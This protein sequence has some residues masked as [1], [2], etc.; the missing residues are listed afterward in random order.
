MLDKEVKAV[1]E[2]EGEAVAL[3]EELR[4]WID[5]EQLKEIK[6]L[7]ADGHEMLNI[8]RFGNGVHNKKYAITI[9][10]GAIGNFEDVIDL[11]ESEGN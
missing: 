9:L 8:V 10:D 7:M 4:S 2:V 3:I 6:G 1:E 11:L 5:D